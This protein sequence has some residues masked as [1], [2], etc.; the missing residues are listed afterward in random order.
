MQKTNSNWQECLDILRE[1]MQPQSY[2]T[3]L[4]PTKLIDDSNGE[5]MI[6]VPNRFIASWLEGH[7]INHINEAVETTFG[8]K[9]EIRFTI[10][11]DGQTIDIPKFAVSTEK[12]PFFHAETFLNQR[13]TFD[14]FVVGD[15]NQFAHAATL[16][17]AEAP[18]GNKFNPLYIYGGVGLGKT[19]L[20]QA[21]G[22]F[23]T[24]TNQNLSVL[25]VTSEKFTNDF[26]NAISTQK[27]SEFATR[28]R[29]IDLLIIDDIQFLS[30]KE[31]TQ[32]Q[33]FHTF[34]TL[35]Q[36]SRQV[37]LTSDRPPQEIYGLEER[38]L[39]RFQCGLVVDIQPPDFEMRL[40]ILNKKIETEDLNIPPNVAAFIANN[41]SSNIRELEG[42]LIRLGAYYSLTGREIT[43]ELV[44]EIIG[45]KSGNRPKELSL[46]EINKK[47]AEYFKI[48]SD[49]ITGK[50]K[51][52]EVSTA[53][54][55]AIYIARN[56]TTYSLKTIGNFFGGRDHSTIIHS[57]KKITQAM[58]QDSLLKFR[59]EEIV[60]RLQ[61]E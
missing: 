42:F 20:A 36:S 50:S 44:K 61:T 25:Y 2:N 1:R 30:G 34:N 27:T 58:G 12:K 5:L 46:D 55:I 15:S 23:V 24:Q 47:V 57:I 41:I 43:C 10:S 17:V 38:L 54:Q 14:S 4:K 11:P 22:N 28:Y 32:D 59:I 18:T 48:P 39:S 52:V 53:R 31:A 6:S 21:I 56:N 7:Y 49:R 35:H 51:T 26:I 9:K 16:A 60:K 45:K 13:Y 33:F 19:H 8:E 29:S 37:V 3:W 40:A